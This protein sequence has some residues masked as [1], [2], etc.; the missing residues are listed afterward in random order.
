MWELFI[1]FVFVLIVLTLVGFTGKKKRLKRTDSSRGICLD[2]QTTLNADL[3]VPNTWPNYPEQHITSFRSFSYAAGKKREW[4]NWLLLNNY[5]VIVAFALGAHEDIQIFVEFYAK[6]P[7]YVEDN[8]L[9]FVVGNEQTTSDVPRIVEDIALLRKLIEEEQLPR[10]PV[11]S[12]MNL[13]DSGTQEW[14]LPDTS[15]PP[16]NAKF[17]TVYREVAKHL[18]IICF[19]AY[20]GFFDMGGLTKDT[21]SF[22]TALRV[23][24]SWKTGDS[25]IVNQLVAVRIAMKDAGLDHLPFWLTETG[26]SS[27]PLT[28]DGVPVVSNSEGDPQTTEKWSNLTNEKMFY[29]SFMDFDLTKNI[30]VDNIYDVK[31]PDKMFYFSLRDSKLLSKDIE[32]Y[33]GLFTSDTTTLVHKMLD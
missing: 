15:Y 11:T 5:K 21:K 16:Q 32:E 1:L 28:I 13:N 10:L 26:W 8:V 22:D 33:F 4:T 31:P 12:V 24:L 19:N 6:H 9:A 7:T 18:D 14:L 23:S 2:D 25:V 20:G 17:S 30:K 3:V 27:A 29:N